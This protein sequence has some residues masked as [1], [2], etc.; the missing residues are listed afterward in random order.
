MRDDRRCE[1]AAGAG[2][3]HAA[4]GGAIKRVKPDGHRVRAAR[5]AFQRRS[6]FT[7]WDDPALS[8]RRV[9]GRAAPGRS[10]EPH[11]HGFYVNEFNDDAGRMRAT[12]GVNFDRMVALKTKFD[13]NN[14]FRLNANVAPEGHA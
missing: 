11:T 5:R 3:E 9:S 4:G 14:L 8:E 1:P 2:G 6:C 10:I 12:Y 13:P 7:R